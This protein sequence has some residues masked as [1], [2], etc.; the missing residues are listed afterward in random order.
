MAPNPDGYH[1]V[2]H[3]SGTGCDPLDLIESQG[4]GFH[5]GNIVKYVSRW[6]RKGG[7][8]DLRKAR[9]YLDRL[10]AAAE[11]IEEEKEI[12]SAGEID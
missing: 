1:L 9:V 4:L 10:I 5:E 2:S 7:S 12:N 11:E 3:Y 8:S 6:R